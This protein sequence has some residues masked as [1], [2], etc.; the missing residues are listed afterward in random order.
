MRATLRFSR[1]LAAAALL[2]TAVAFLGVGLEHTPVSRML[3]AVH[4]DRG[5]SGKRVI[6]R[7]GHIPNK[8]LAP[9]GGGPGPPSNLASWPSV[10]HVLLE[11]TL[12]ALVVVA[13]DG[14]RRLARRHRHGRRRA[15]AM[16][17]FASED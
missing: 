9:R 17:S 7:F 12:I 11:I 10:G 8:H 13:L 15:L 4:G 2:V 6:D 5:E 1:H 3:P 14:I 16:S